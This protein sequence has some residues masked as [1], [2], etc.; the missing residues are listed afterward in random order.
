MVRIKTRPEVVVK[1]AVLHN[2]SF[3]IGVLARMLWGIL[4]LDPPIESQANA[5]EPPTSQ[6]PAYQCHQMN[7]CPSKISVPSQGLLRDG[8]CSTQR[9][10]SLRWYLDMDSLFFGMQWPILPVF[11]FSAPGD[12]SQVFCWLDAITCVSR[13][14]SLNVPSY[15]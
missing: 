7:H 2:A 3:I 8:I 5:S 6:P 15:S 1:V 10:T 12:N 11:R 13:H 4:A 14:Q 9:Y